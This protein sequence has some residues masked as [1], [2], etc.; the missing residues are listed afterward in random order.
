MRLEL[1]Q[2]LCEAFPLLYADRH[3]PKEK[4]CMYWGFPGDGWF[5]LLW[6]LSEN[7]EKLL[8]EIQEEQYLCACG[9]TKEAHTRLRLKFW[10]GAKCKHLFEYRA[11]ATPCF[12]FGFQPVFPRAAQVKEKFGTLRFYMTNYSP[13]IRSIINTYLCISGYTCEICGNTEGRKCSI[14]LSGSWVKTYCESCERKD[15]ERA[16]HKRE[17]WLKRAQTQK[18]CLPEEV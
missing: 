10:K 16:T 1:D 18:K 11:Q 12:C 2:K 14:G 8:Q 4:T 15:K 5:D 13:S 3:G 6:N 7:L 17:E 9:H